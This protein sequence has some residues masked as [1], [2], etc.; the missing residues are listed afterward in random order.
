MNTAEIERVIWHLGIASCRIKSGVRNHLRLA[1]MDDFRLL[2]RYFNCSASDILEKFW[3]AVK[4]LYG[5]A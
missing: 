3:Q 5:K 2:C 1:G 4:E